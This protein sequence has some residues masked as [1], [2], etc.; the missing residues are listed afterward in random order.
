MHYAKSTD[1]VQP[2]FNFTMYFTIRKTVEVILNIILKKQKLADFKDSIS[3]KFT[4]VFRRKNMRF[5]Q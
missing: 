5:I 3:E 1:E 4:K 2:I